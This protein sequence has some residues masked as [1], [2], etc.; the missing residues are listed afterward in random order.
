M[1]KQDISM[2][3]G[4]L[5]FIHGTSNSIGTGEEVNVPEYGD[6]DLLCIGLSTHYPLQPVDHMPPP[7]MSP[8]ESGPVATFD[9]FYSF[10]GGQS[11][12]DS[13]LAHTNLLFATCGC[14]L[15]L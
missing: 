6:H 1:V 4:H 8:Q 7:T 3:V 10:C 2:F 15:V 14:S 13:P 9:H 11:V 5:L 12:V